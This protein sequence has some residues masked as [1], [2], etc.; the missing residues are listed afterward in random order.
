MSTHMYICSYPKAKLP[1][2][3][4]TSWNLYLEVDHHTA[5]NNC[6]GQNVY[7]WDHRLSYVREAFVK[8]FPKH[9]G[10]SPDMEFSVNETMM[11]KFILEMEAMYGQ[12]CSGVPSLKGIVRKFNFETHYMTVWCEW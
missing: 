7:L 5:V 8:S 3:I 11:R 12:D 6:K 2:E 4:C 9:T 1:P 10:L